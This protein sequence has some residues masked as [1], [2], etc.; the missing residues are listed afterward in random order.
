MDADIAALANGM[1][2]KG[3]WNASAGTFP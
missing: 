3:D 1:I 2:Y